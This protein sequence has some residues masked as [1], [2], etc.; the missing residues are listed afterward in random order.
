MA[1]SGLDFL[2]DGVGFFLSRPNKTSRPR[3]APWRGFFLCGCP[4]ENLTN[5]D[6]DIDV[7][8][9][10]LAVVGA[11]LV[12]AHIMAQVSRIDVGRPYR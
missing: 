12:V 11:T 10:N 7:F 8:R 3:Q 1:R 9:A 5:S 6:I 2:Q 4:Y